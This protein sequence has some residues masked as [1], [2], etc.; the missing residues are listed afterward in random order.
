MVHG[1]QDEAREEA[2]DVEAGRAVDGELGVD[3]L[4]C[5]LLLVSVGSIL[6][7]GQDWGRCLLKCT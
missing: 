6:I 5:P 7:P 3:D 1:C 4:D 2:A